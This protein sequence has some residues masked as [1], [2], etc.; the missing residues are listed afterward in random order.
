MIV[1]VNYFYW[2]QISYIDPAQIISITERTT[3]W[4]L[5]T[6]YENI[7]VDLANEA[8]DLWPDD[9]F[10]TEYVS[11]LV[12]I[13]Q[14]ITYHNRKLLC[15]SSTG[16]GDAIPVPGCVRIEDFSM[17]HGNGCTPDRLRSKLRKLKSYEEYK[18][19]V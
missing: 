4:L 1:I 19:P 11:R 10:K 3:D 7:L 14:N 8:G 17:P 6:G 5:R 13:A 9:R 2:R 12:E 16:G 18:K 15:S